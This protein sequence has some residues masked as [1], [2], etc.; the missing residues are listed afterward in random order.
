M[1]STRSLSDGLSAIP[2]LRHGELAEQSLWEIE[3]VLASTEEIC[4]EAAH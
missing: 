3:K 4:N 1:V 2:N